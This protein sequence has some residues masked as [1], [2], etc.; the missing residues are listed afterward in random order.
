[1]QLAWKKALANRVIFTLLFVNA[2]VR[3]VI[4]IFLPKHPTELA[5]DEGAYANLALWI[6]DG[7]SPSNFPTYGPYLYYASRSLVMPSVLLV[8]FGVN[9]LL[10]VR[11]V[12][13]TYGFLSAV[14]LYLLF[15]NLLFYRITRS[16]STLE[17]GNLNAI[18]ISLFAIASFLPSPL[19]WSSLGLRESSSWFWLLLS[20]YLIAKLIFEKKA[21][22]FKLA[23][24]VALAFA[25]ALSFAGRAQTSSL[26]FVV[27]AFI[28]VLSLRRK[29][30][31]PGLA[32][33]AISCGFLLGLLYT[34][35][36][37][38][39]PDLFEPTKGIALTQESVTQTFQKSLGNQLETLADTSAEQDS[40]REGANSSLPPYECSTSLSASVSNIMCILT[41][42]PYRSFAF[43]FRPILMFDSGSNL[44][45]LASI[46]NVCWSLLF[47]WLILFFF[48]T[49]DNW[50]RRIL[51]TPMLCFI[52]FFVVAAGLIEGNMGN[53]FRHKS[54]VLWPLVCSLM[55]LAQRDFD[56]KE[57]DG[58]K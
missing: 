47:I 32:L 19:L 23:L 46:E 12:S 58:H 53:A 56:L 52:F 42:I 45:L 5:P 51:V 8:D 57:G 2:I 29:S 13:T 25:F 27:F 10:A 54:I 50:T 49:G 9:E 15:K 26:F 22:A 17:T 6:S 40:T 36:P 1:M 31:A 7:L 20:T 24:S 43:L 16:G 34:S 28:I 39:G 44:M 30:I 48:K 38:G 33:T 41:N 14:V 21:F 18:Q 11:L 3:M 37:N 55:L 4:Q 35:V